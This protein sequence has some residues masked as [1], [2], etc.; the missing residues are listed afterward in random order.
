MSEPERDIDV[1]P[2]L[3]AGVWANDVD[4]FG[5]VEDVDAR[6]RPYRPARSDV[7][8]VVA[9]VMLP[10]FCILKLKRDLERFAMIELRAEA[11]AATR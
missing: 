10:L 9:R 11:L 3:Q 1:P 5:D 2:E 4:V 7:G 8:V 6:F